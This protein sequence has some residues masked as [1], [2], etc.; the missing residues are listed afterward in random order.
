VLPLALLLGACASVAGSPSDACA[1]AA[2]LLGRQMA[3]SG[4]ALPSDAP[5][6]PEL[7]AALRLANLHLLLSQEAAARL[8][9]CRS[10]Q[11]QTVREDEAAGRIWRVTAE[12]R[13]ARIRAALREEIELALAIS[14][15][16]GAN[17]AA[18]VAAASPG[19]AATSAEARQEAELR[20]LVA[21][22]TARRESFATTVLLAG[23]L[24]DL[25]M[26]R[27]ETGR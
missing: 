8:F 2:A 25:E 11:A 26:D 7:V 6:R 10:A 24:T 9:E 22:N 16:I 14:E 13:I 15:R 20:N 3:G 1:P 17:D 18:L 27:G 12:I 5:R 4:V 23:Q 19:G 21:A